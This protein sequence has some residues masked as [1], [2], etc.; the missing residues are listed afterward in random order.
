MSLTKIKNFFFPGPS[1]EACRVAEIARAAERVFSHA[2][3]VLQYCEQ[4]GIRASAELFHD[5]SGALHIFNAL[6]LTDETQLY[7]EAQLQ[8]CRWEVG[9]GVAT[10]SSCRRRH[11]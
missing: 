4:H 2:Y 9:E 11:P 6:A 7:L 3:T 10:L 5:G 1:R 8:S